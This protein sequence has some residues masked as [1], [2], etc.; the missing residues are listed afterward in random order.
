MGEEAVTVIGA[1]P[2]RAMIVKDA[3]GIMN[4]FKEMTNKQRA[5]AIESFAEF[6]AQNVPVGGNMR[7]S[8]GYRTLLVKVLTRRA[9]EEVG[10]MKN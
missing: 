6:A 3:N 1:R 8:A 9:W 10:G 7:A 2:G 4:G 5:A